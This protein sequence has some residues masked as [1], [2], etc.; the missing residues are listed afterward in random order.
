MANKTSNKQQQK[1]KTGNGQR[2][3]VEEPKY[4]DTE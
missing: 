1:E 3:K 4:S 2:K